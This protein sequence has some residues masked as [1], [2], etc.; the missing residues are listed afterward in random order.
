MLYCIFFHKPDNLA[1]EG[2]YQLN[3]SE[4]LHSKWKER[5]GL[6]LVGAS[7]S[8]LVQ[9]GAELYPILQVFEENTSKRL[10]SLLCILL[11]LLLLLSLYSLYYLCRNPLK[12]KFGLYWDKQ[13]NP[14]CP[15]CQKPLHGFSKQNDTKRYGGKCVVCGK[16]VQLDESTTNKS[17]DEIHSML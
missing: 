6:M 7:G 15:G 16:F 10:L 17:L 13:K 2:V 8:I 1:K 12:L 5:I 9:I 11:L 14:Y 3:N 4:D